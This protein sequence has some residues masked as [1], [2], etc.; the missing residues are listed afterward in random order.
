MLLGVRMV[1]RCCTEMLPQAQ[2][3]DKVGTCLGHT[4]ILEFITSRRPSD[5]RWIRAHR[6][7]FY[8]GIKT[9]MQSPQR[10]TQWSMLLAADT[11]L[12]RRS[13]HL[14]F[15]VAASNS[16]EMPP[17]LTSRNP[18]PGIRRSDPEPLNLGIYSLEVTLTSSDLLMIH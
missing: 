5:S 14:P 1:K 17:S 8:F 13:L 15:S 11:E 2:K 10:I 9:H 12:H 3:S 4:Y 18:L 16:H 7:T 6:S